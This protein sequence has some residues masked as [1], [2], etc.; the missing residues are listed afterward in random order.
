MLVIAAIITSI[1]IEQLLRAHVKLLRAHVK[2]LR[3]HVN[4][5]A[6]ARKAIAWPRKRYC[7]ARKAIVWPRK[8][9]CYARKAIVWPR[10]RYCYA[11]KAIVWPI[12]GASTGV[13]RLLLNSGFCGNLQSIKAR[14]IKHCKKVVGNR[15]YMYIIMFPRQACSFVCPSVKLFV[16]IRSML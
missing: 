10:K 6:C 12:L 2:L 9:Y 13:D 14:F 7:Y 5:I 1:F 4:V 11:R 15:F 16:E 3:G 8:R